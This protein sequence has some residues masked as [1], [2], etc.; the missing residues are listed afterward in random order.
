MGSSIGPCDAVGDV[1]FQYICP[2]ERHEYT[3]N[4][5]QPDLGL[6]FPSAGWELPEPHCAMTRHVAQAV[7][8]Q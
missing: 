4:A 2:A 3:L 6:S 1:T 5:V 7:R 8:A